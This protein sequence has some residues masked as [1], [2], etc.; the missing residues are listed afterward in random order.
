MIVVFI[1]YIYIIII[2]IFIIF[3]FI[4]IVI[5]TIIIIYIYPIRPDH[6][7]NVYGNFEIS[8]YDSHHKK[9]WLWHGT[10][11]CHWNAGRTFDIFDPYLVITRT[12]LKLRRNYS[13]N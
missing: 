11:P 4:F 7:L 3:I 12:L 1:I 9:G 6:F 10:F 13:D 8:M 2:I 5:I